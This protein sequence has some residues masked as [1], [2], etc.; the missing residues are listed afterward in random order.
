MS[1]LG[2]TEL[3]KRTT[4]E[5]DELMERSAKKKKG[6]EKSYEPGSSVP[7]SYA[8]I[9]ESSRKGEQHR[10]RSYKDSVLGVTSDDDLEEEETDEFA[11]GEGERTWRVMTVN[12]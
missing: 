10:T 8:D 2:F 1:L 11:D 4:D 5:E 12:Y 3:T 6:G 7:I 9:H